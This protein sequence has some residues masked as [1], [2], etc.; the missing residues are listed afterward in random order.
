MIS[1]ME[2]LAQAENESR[3]QNIR[4]GLAMKAVNGTFG[5]YKRKLKCRWYNQKN[6]QCRHSLSDWKRKKK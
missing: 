1:I 3:S 5:L 4:M 6:F 2:S